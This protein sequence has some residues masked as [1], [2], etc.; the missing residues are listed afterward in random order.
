M[1]GDDFLHKSDIGAVTLNLQ[2]ADKVADAAAN[3]SAAICQSHGRPQQFLAERM[4]TGAIAELIVGIKRDD[5]FGL[6]LV[7]GAGGILVE[8][9]A[10]CVSLLLPTDRVAVMK[11][12]ES[13]SVANL[14]KGFRGSAA[15]DMNVIVDAILSVAKFA[16]NNRDSLMELDIN[17]LLV[18]PDGQGVV[19][20][21]ALIRFSSEDS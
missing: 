16:E 15:G 17:P 21:D 18:L 3:I 2:N 12:V 11:A 1:H 4:A 19:A 5:Q 8:L 20:A 14:I 6:A 9:V 13:I 10:D 7:I